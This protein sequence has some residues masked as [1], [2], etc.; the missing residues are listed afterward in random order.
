M[1]SRG[2]LEHM[3]RT[4]GKIITVIDLSAAGNSAI[5]PVKEHTFK[6]TIPIYPVTEG[7]HLGELQQFSGV[8]FFSCHEARAAI[9]QSVE[10][11]KGF[12]SMR[13]T[14]GGIPG[15]MESNSEA[16]AKE[17]QRKD[18]EKVIFRLIEGGFSLHRVITPQKGLKPSEGQ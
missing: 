9:L 2:I 8:S 13:G 12:S 6:K 17:W 3:Q 1:A 7:G 5:M 15:Q 14:V 18:G 10:S 4:D 11:V 16:T